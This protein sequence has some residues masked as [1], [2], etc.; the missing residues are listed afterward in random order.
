MLRQAL[1]PDLKEVEDLRTLYPLLDIE[2]NPCYNADELQAYYRGKLKELR[3]LF[4]RDPN[5][6]RL[7][8]GMDS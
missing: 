3:T 8:K 5:T 6:G 7:K 1:R 2:E 4:G